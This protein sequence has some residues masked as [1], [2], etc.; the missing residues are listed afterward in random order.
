MGGA[1]LTVNC[2]RIPLVGS[3]CAH[4][5]GSLTMKLFVCFRGSYYSVYT[6]TLT[7]NKTQKLSVA[8]GHARAYT[9]VQ[10][11]RGYRHRMGELTLWVV[12]DFW[13]VL[14]FWERSEGKN[15]CDN[16]ALRFEKMYI[17]KKTCL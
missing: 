14:N 9:R 8:K 12:K 17:F 4:V 3:L 16:N 6:K 2:S 7:A 5:L 10:N 11:P 15:I 1:V 13:R